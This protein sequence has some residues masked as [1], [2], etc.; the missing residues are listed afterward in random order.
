MKTGK[1]VSFCIDSNYAKGTN[2]TLKSRR[3]LVLED[4][5]GEFM[6]TTTVAYSKSTRENHI[7]VRGKVGSEAN[8]VSCGDG[9]SNQSTQ[10]F[11]A[12]KG[13]NLRI[14]KLTPV[15][16]ER[17]QGYDDNYT[18]FGR[19][20]DDTV[21]EMSNTQRYKMVGNGVSASVSK[22]IL[23]KLITE[24]SI[25]VMSTFSGC[26]GTEHKLSSRFKIIGHSE[27]DKYA[28]D[29]LRFIHPEVPNFGDI[30]KINTQDLPDFDLLLGGF[31]CQDISV[32]GK[33]QGFSKEDGTPTRSGL[34]FELIRILKDK[35]PKY[36]M[37]ENVKNLLSIQNG[38]LMV[39]VLK[40]ISTL[41]YDVDFELVNSKDYGLAQNRQR[42]FI[43]GVRRDVP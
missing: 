4:R 38:A 15:E 29:T 11:V 25:K 20:Q 40:E 18:R 37:F 30:T 23:E 43:F 21:Y 33:R 14:R 31:P 41:G 9:G 36:L 7:D 16:C 34:F 12:E 24:D 6:K 35:E 17:L 1:D 27:F 19:K 3:Q 42:V 13:S 10:N 32:A 28:S 8:T 26:G 5:G 39:L 2:T 22:A